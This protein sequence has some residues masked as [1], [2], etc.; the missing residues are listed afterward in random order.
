MGNI[1]KKILKNIYEASKMGLDSIEYIYPKVDD[2]NMKKDLDEYKRKYHDIIGE[3]KYRMELLKTKPE[4]Y[5]PVLKVMLWTGIQAQTMMDNSPSNIAEL[6]IKG[7][8]KGIVEM[9]KDI[10]NDLADEDVRKIANTLVHYEKENINN[11]KKYL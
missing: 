2:K 5:S 11:M 4:D 6:L 7:S 3:T 10:N 8:T 1:D 9:T